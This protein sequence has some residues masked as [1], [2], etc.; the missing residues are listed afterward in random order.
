MPAVLPRLALAIER[1]RLKYFSFG[2][3]G[4]LEIDIDLRALAESSDSW[5]KDFTI[6]GLEFE[7]RFIVGYVECAVKGRIQAK[8][9]VTASAQA[10]AQTG[11][12]AV[13]PITYLYEYLDWY[14]T[15][16]SREVPGGRATTFEGKPIELTLVEGEL[17]VKQTARFVK[18]M[19]ARVTSS[20]LK[21]FVK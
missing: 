19:A 3:D 15:G 17:T 13:I 10:Q 8:I 12:T 5:N 6:P 4:D 2:L 18:W 14:P 9:D 11:L 20:T 16:I 21:L 1:Q 7:K